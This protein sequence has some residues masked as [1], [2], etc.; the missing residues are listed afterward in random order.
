MATIQGTAASDFLT[1]TELD[2][3]INGKAGN[4]AI[5]AGATVQRSCGLSKIGL[6]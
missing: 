3:L 1:G 2:E 5:S 4:D 6:R